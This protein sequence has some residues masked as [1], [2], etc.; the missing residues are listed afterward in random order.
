MA[1]GTFGITLLNRVQRRRLKHGIG[2]NQK[3]TGSQDI[4][5]WGGSYQRRGG[6]YLVP[7][8]WG[9]SHYWRMDY[10]HQGRRRTMSLG[11]YPEIG[12]EDVRSLARAARAKLLA[13]VDPMDDRQEQR[14]QHRQRAESIQRVQS[15][16]P[17]IGS[18]EEI[19]RRWFE[20]KKGQRME[21]YSSKV[22]RRLELHAFPRF[23]HTPIEKITPKTV[24]EACRAVERNDTLETAHRL[25]EHCSCVFRFAIAEGRD[26]RDPCQDIRDALKRPVVKHKVFDLGAFKIL[27]DTYQMVFSQH[28]N[29]SEATS[30]RMLAYHGAGLIQPQATAYLP[31]PANLDWHANQVFKSPARA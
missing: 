28:L 10:T 8:A 21:S 15:G 12:L 5:T 30:Q 1:F 2:K 14:E 31:H 23:G 27:P 9:E 6:L 18:F 7:F 22:I 3:R 11:A 29:G 13:G 17:P 16:L 26:L 20:V 24:L 19:A 25:R 4:E